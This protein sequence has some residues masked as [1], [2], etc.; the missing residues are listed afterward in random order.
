[1]HRKIFSVLIFHLVVI[2]LAGC[3][4]TNYGSMTVLFATDREKAT[5]PSDYFG[6]GRGL[7][8][9]FGECKVG[10]ATSG[11]PDLQGQ[12]TARPHLLRTNASGILSAPVEYI[13]PSFLGQIQ[14]ALA[15]SPQERI[16][17]FVHGFN[18][19]YKDACSISA[20]LAYDVGFQ[21]VVMTFD[22]PSKHTL[23]G[24]CSDEE[25]AQWAAPHLADFLNSIRQAA[26]DATIDIITHS[27]GSRVV[28]FALLDME[29]EGLKPGTMKLGHIIFLAPDID[30]DIFRQTTMRHIHTLS[31]FTVYGSSSDKALKLSRWIHEGKREGEKP[32]QYTED[33]PKHSANPWFYSVDASGVDTG[34]IGHWYYNGSVAPVTRDLAALLDG[35]YDHSKQALRVLEPAKS[36]GK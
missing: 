18:D 5:Y 28:T 20:Q 27:M 33:S 7:G 4:A 19:S 17:L 3:A 11:R 13:R 12:E 26:P 2:S 29:F 9:T 25:S 35:A 31:N 21:G 32:D 24:Y 14:T 34:T 30:V 6:T 15:K 10:V 1:M 36:A 8:A 22:W 16:L 23:L